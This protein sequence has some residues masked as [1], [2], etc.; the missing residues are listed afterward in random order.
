MT[1]EKEEAVNTVICEA[2]ININSTNKTQN[3]IND[4]IIEIPIIPKASS[5]LNSGSSEAEAE[6]DLYYEKLLNDFI[7][8]IIDTIDL[9]KKC[10]ISKKDFLFS[11]DHCFNI[12]NKGTIVTGTVLKGKANVNDEVYFPALCEKKVI[13]EMQMFKK[14]VLKAFE[15]D[16]VG[17]LIKNLDHTKIERSLACSEGFVQA[18]DGGLFLM[19]KIK[20]FKNDV[21]SNSKMFIIF[22]NQGVN[23]K[24]TF[25]SLSN[26]PVEHLLKKLNNN[27]SSTNPTNTVNNKD[28]TN[29]DNKDNNENNNNTTSENTENKSFLNTE[30]KNIGVNLKLFYLEEFNFNENLE[31]SEQFQFAILKFDNKILVAPETVAL[32]SKIDFDISHKSNRIAFYGKII[33]KYEENQVN[34]IKIYKNKAKQ[35]KILRM[36]TDNIA[37]VINLFKKDSNLDDFIGKPVYVLE[38]DKKITGIIQSK[39]GQ[40]GKVKVEFNEILKNIQLNDSTGKEIDFSQF[41]VV[42]EYKKYVKLKK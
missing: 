12:K 20:Y 14:P 7:L 35:G 2:E 31:S 19:R 18:I 5:D 37:V 21:K 34:K 36:A 27:N 42:M 11:I 10:E 22:G 38:S 24:C 26:T 17:M 41:T 28:C 9:N 15:G 25:F 3:H 29:N 39:F 13:K 6:E 4:E 30:I 8:A 33:D 16:R 1:L 40:T 32:G 23:A